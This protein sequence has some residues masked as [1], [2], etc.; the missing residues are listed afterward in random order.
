MN[1]NFLADDRICDLGNQPAE[2]LA[3]D[4]YFLRELLELSVGDRRGSCHRIPQSGMSINTTD[5]VVG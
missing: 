5:Y 3:L 4:F 1:E 2:W